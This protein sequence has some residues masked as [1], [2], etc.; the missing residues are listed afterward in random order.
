[1]VEIERSTSQTLRRPPG[2]RRCRLTDGARGRAVRAH[3]VRQERAPRWRWPTRL[4]G[5][6]VSLR[7]DAALPRAAGADQPAHAPS[8]LARGAAPPGRRLAAVARGLGGRVRRAGPRG[9]RRRC[10]ARGRDAI[11][12]RRQ[13]PLPAGG[14]GR[15]WS[16]RRRRPPACA[17][18]TSGCYD[19]RGAGGRARRCWPSA[20]PPPPPPSTRTTAGA[21]CARSSWPSRRVRWPRPRTTLWPEPPA[22]HGDPAACTWP[23]DAGRAAGSRPRT[24]AMFERGVEHEVARRAGRRAVGTRPPASTACRTCVRC[25]TARSTA[26]RRAGAWSCAPASTRGASGSGCGGCPG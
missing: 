3:R 20:I 19:E 10:M 1:M 22:R 18:A 26:T 4:G 12:V 24:G 13:R 25:S 16:C 17:S 2:R 7:R 8:E 21:W 15:R 14:A 5:E 6:I 9:D 11:V 23:A